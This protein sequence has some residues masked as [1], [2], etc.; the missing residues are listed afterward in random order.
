MSDGIFFTTCA[1]DIPINNTPESQRLIQIV[2]FEPSATAKK[3]VFKPD[4]AGVFNAMHPVLSKVR[5]SF[6]NDTKAKKGSK[7]QKIAPFPDTL[8][9][10]EK[11]IA[12]FGGSFS[13]F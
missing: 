2:S 12:K 10:F 11:R 8:T 5:V 6:S 9:D 7:R 1:E 13:N 4:V 3:A